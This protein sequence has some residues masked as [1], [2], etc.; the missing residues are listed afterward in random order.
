MKKIRESLVLGS[1]SCS[2]LEQKNETQPWTYYLFNARPRSNL[3][4]HTDTTY[5]AHPPAAKFACQSS[6]VSAIRELAEFTGN[7]KECMSD[8]SIGEEQGLQIICGFN[9]F[10]AI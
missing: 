6:A 7:Q 5:I 10:L 8:N 2:I 1:F 4:P 9:L 3:K